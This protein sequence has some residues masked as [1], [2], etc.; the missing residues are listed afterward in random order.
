N[1]VQHPPKRFAKDS[2]AP[3][4]T[5]SPPFQHSSTHTSHHHHHHSSRNDL[6]SLPPTALA[7]HSLAHV[8]RPTNATHCL[9]KAAH[10]TEH[11]S[12][13]TSPPRH[14]TSPDSKSFSR[15]A[16]VPAFLSLPAKDHPSAFFAP[17]LV[18]SVF[19]DSDSLPPSPF[20]L[21]DPPIPGEDNEYYADD[22]D[23]DVAQPAVSMMHHSVPPHRGRKGG[24]RKPL[25]AGGVSSP[26]PVPLPMS[27][28]PVGSVASM[29]KMPAQMPSLSEKKKALRHSRS[30]VKLGSHGSSSGCGGVVGGGGGTGIESESNN[31][32]QQQQQRR[33]H[34]NTNS[35]NKIGSPRTSSGVFVAPKSLS[36]SA[37]GDQKED[38]DDEEMGIH[39]ALN[40]IAYRVAIHSH[41]VSA[42]HNQITLSD[43]AHHMFWDKLCL[44]SGDEWSTTGFIPALHHASTIFLIVSRALLYDK[45]S[46]H[47]LSCNEDNVLLEWE[48]AVDLH[49]AGKCVVVPVWVEDEGGVGSR[50]EVV[51]GATMR[52]YHV[53]SYYEGLGVKPKRC[54][55]ETV[56]IVLGL[57]GVTVCVDREGKVGGEE[58]WVARLLQ[59]CKIVA[60]DGKE[61]GKGMLTK[62]EDVELRAIL[63]GLKVFEEWY[64]GEEVVGE[65][66]RKLLNVMAHDVVNWIGNPNT[67]VL[68]VRTEGL[69]PATHTPLSYLA[70][71]IRH[72][73]T[74][75][76]LFG[77]LSLS[78]T[79]DTLRA[80]LLRLIYAIA[81]NN[82]HHMRP[83]LASLQNLGASLENETAVSIPTLVTNFILSAAAAAATP[84][85]EDGGPRQILLV[86]L[87]GG[88]LPH[89]DVLQ[90]LGWIVRGFEAAV[91]VVV[92]V[93]KSGEGKVGGLRDFLDERCGGAVAIYGWEDAREECERSG[94]G[95]G[96]GKVEVGSRGVGG[97]VGGGAK[98]GVEDGELG[99]REEEGILKE[100]ETYRPGFEG[101]LKQETY[102]LICGEVE[103][104]KVLAHRIRKQLTH[105]TS[106]A[107]VVDRKTSMTDFDA[108]LKRTNFVLVLISDRLMYDLY[109]MELPDAFIQMVQD[110]LES[111]S[112]R[113]SSFLTA[114]PE[115]RVTKRKDIL[116]LV[117]LLIGTHEGKNFSSFGSV[118]KSKWVKPTM[119]SLFKIQGEHISLVT[120]DSVVVRLAQL[121]QFHL[122]LTAADLFDSMSNGLS[123]EESEE[124]RR[125]L[126][127]VDGLVAAQQNTLLRQYERG[128]RGW[129]KDRVMEWV[130]KSDKRVLWL[131]GKAGVGKSVMAA[132]VSQHLEDH[133]MLASSFFCKS[134]NASLSNARNIVRTIAFS[135]TK[136]QPSYGRVLLKLKK[137]LDTDFFSSP[138]S[139]IFQKVVLQPLQGYADFLKSNVEQEV[140]P[141]VIVLDAIDEA[142]S[143]G[144][145][146]DLLNIFK[147]QC[148]ELPSF[149]KIFVTSRPDADIVDSFG[150]LD[151]ETI[152]PSDVENQLDARIAAEN[153]IM[154]MDRRLEPEEATR[155]AQMLVDKSSGLF[156]WLTLALL[157]LQHGGVVSAAAID[158]IQVGMSATLQTVFK[159]MFRNMSD[160]ILSSVI[161][162]ITLLQEPLSAVDISRLM[163]LESKQIRYCVRTLQAVLGGSF[164]DEQE[165]ISFLHKC[166]VDFL[167]GAQGSHAQELVSSEY[168][169]ETLSHF[170]TDK[171]FV[172]TATGGNTLLAKKCLDTLNQKL[173]MVPGEV[174]ECVERSCLFKKAGE[175]V[176][177]SFSYRYFGMKNAS[178]P[179]KPDRQSHYLTNDLTHAC[180]FWNRYITAEN[181][182]EVVEQLEEFASKNLAFWVEAMVHLQELDQVHSIA[183]GVSKLLA[184]PAAGAGAHLDK[185]HLHSISHL[186]GDIA[187]VASRFSVPLSWNPLQM[188]ETVMAFAPRLSYFYAGYRDGNL[189]YK[190]L[191]D[192]RADWGP[193]MTICE[194]VAVV[195]CTAYSHD[196]AMVATGGKDAVLRIWSTTTGQL[197][198]SFEGHAEEVLSVAFLSDGDSI[199]S[200]GADKCVK[201]WSLSV[202]RLLKSVKIGVSVVRGVAISL[203]GKLL[204][205]SFDDSTIKVWLLDSWKVLCS[206]DD[207]NC[208]ARSLSFSCDAKLL[209]SGSQAHVKVWSVRSAEL[210]KSF[211]GNAGCVNAVQISLD[212]DTIV[213]G[214]DD[215]SIR[216]WSLGG[217]K[218]R[219]LLDH[220]SPVTALALSA[221]GLMIASGAAD[222][223]VKLFSTSRNQCIKSFEGHSDAVKCL[224]V[225][226]DGFSVASG[227]S[228]KSLKVWSVTAKPAPVF[229]DNHTS[230]VSI[231]KCSPD[232]KFVVTGAGDGFARVWSLSSGLVLSVMEF[233]SPIV[234][235]VW[236]AKGDFVAVGSETG[237]IGVWS[238][239]T[240]QQTASLTSTAH[241][242]AVSMDFT[243]D[244]K[245]FVAYASPVGQIWN[246]DTCTLDTELKVSLARRKF[247]M[248]S[249]AVSPTSDF[250]AVA[251][252]DPRLKLFTPTGTFY[253]SFRDH[254]AT[255]TCCA[256]S[257]DGKLIVSGSADKTIRVVHLEQRKCIHVFKGHVAG[258]KS[259][260][261]KTVDTIVSEDEEGT[262]LAWSLLDGIEPS[263][264]LVANPR[265]LY[266]S[267]SADGWFRCLSEVLI[268]IPHELRGI[269]ASTKSHIVLG[270]ANGV[271]TILRAGK[272][273]TNAQRKGEW[274]SR[275]HSWLLEHE[276]SLIKF[277]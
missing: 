119:E 226:L 215:N 173:S 97:A 98:M 178:V 124:L 130:Q 28:I 198:K 2:F 18:S 5:T 176:T 131:Q 111:A 212:N 276:E 100:M 83:Y 146:V 244:N 1:S 253:K 108:L 185:S 277:G 47:L 181:E 106:I 53:H 74:T 15:T 86:E 141:V 20:E 71:V 84:A 6:A 270:A 58:G 101:H 122:Q 210:V 23:D 94:G 114:K 9:C 76:T 144:K 65:T 129:L 79:P 57:L 237:L 17:P 163:G 187:L 194:T 55:R 242:S 255:V 189:F 182:L 247:D 168:A 204:A 261:F 203:D 50:G 258:I 208:V 220:T 14:P 257:P 233:T 126:M 151:Q 41:I 70:P 275:R 30:P 164:L 62:R 85:N 77:V 180:K 274:L 272:E 267:I 254:T 264:E 232:A 96:E 216:I 223:T 21:S 42:L 199:L 246:L 250:L 188:Y 268:W 197:V 239:L 125:W 153:R 166:V 4:H 221:N 133:R 60:G 249:C 134:N 205:V 201:I 241:G 37:V 243:T 213:S 24:P 271:V 209:V 157:Q 192:Q 33:R 252:A 103:D 207:P 236:S 99:E 120:L 75:N 34:N 155:L 273:E 66:T 107:A 184:K 59:V 39:R 10:Q 159:G 217:G 123:K 256:F 171:R 104:D 200:V 48:L 219:I 22:D 93:R 49:L 231:I 64:T 167:T 110:A 162:T 260:Q 63:G 140:A 68:L 230:P 183:D 102:L 177:N 211:P 259:V 128:T 56:E 132:L 266:S 193:L 32:R 27:L 150:G 109:S 73:Q 89:P 118:I 161:Q 238:S 145:R 16:A 234:S 190:V 143:I 218:A 105:S 81:H 172:V 191:G 88:K 248:G 136:W 137:E 8:K 112:R 25:L 251:T 52:E 54:V 160:P 7:Q 202:E 156:I 13:S 51:V 174:P 92:C 265:L 147:F 12:A 263:I 117:P 45:T 240:G 90:V 19:Y 154:R 80:S 149:V 29:A 169:D 67:N 115:D 46:T 262:W 222:G 228:D 138:V 225:S 165:P 245:L 235:V 44:V 175:T 40:Q 214:W 269:M 135:L 195:N 121:R 78:P 179:M 38:E 87:A 43:A 186:L 127:P 206:F 116:K 72:L 227:S 224:A 196:G 142:G 170:A 36:N 3:A 69:G 26:V 31:S 158:K 61:G 152:S 11:S 35:S 139:V 91:K 148:K 82:P 95:V 113:E 229:E